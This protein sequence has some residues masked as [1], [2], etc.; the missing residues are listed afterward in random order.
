MRRAGGRNQSVVRRPDSNGDTD[1]SESRQQSLLNQLQTDPGGLGVR[2]PLSSALLDLVSQLTSTASLPESVPPMGGKQAEIEQAEIHEFKGEV[3]V[4]GAGERH[5]VDPSD[6]MQGALGDCYLMALLAAIARSRPE[7]IRRMITDNGNGTYTVTFYTS[8]LGGIL[9]RSKKEITVDSQFWTKLDQPTS[10]V[11]A[12]GTERVASSSGKLENRPE[13][14]VMIIEKAFAQLHG[15]YQS[16]KGSELGGDAAAPITGHSGGSKDPSDYTD[17]ELYQMLYDHFITEDQPVVLWSKNDKES[18]KEPTDSGIV[19]NHGY[20]LMDIYPKS[21]TVDLYNVWGANFKQ[22]S[23]KSMAF[24]RANFESIQLV[25]MNAKRRTV[26]QGQRR[27][28]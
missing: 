21:K 16:I 3:F 5:A 14:W 15:S 27:S 1:R 9:G 20:A 17:D 26:P 23:K 2:I 25:N 10:P 8:I 22:P 6:V 24:I 18:S 19:P 7:F 4:R 11:Y 13:L 12:K 28:R